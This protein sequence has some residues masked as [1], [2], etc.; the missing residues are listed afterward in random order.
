MSLGTTDSMRPT[1][2]ILSADDKN[3]AGAVL[4]QWC[5]LP[6][7]RSQ[8]EQWSCVSL[9]QLGASQRSQQFW[10]LRDWLQTIAT[11][12]T[13]SAAS[14]VTLPSPAA[15]Q[16]SQ[17]NSS[18][19]ADDTYFPGD[20]NVYRCAYTMNGMVCPGTD[21]ELYNLDNFFIN[22]IIEGATV[23]RLPK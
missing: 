7:L 14:T 8:V 4:Q 18:L 17:S 16:D 23:R 5:A 6:W 2:H 9:E 10:W 12:T 21:M 11:A 20:T 19:G 22:E 15:V 13:V 1:A 3:V